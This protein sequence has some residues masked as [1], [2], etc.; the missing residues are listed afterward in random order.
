ME[1]ISSQSRGTFKNSWLDSKHSFSFGEYFNPKRMNF[2]TLRVIN[3]DQVAAN[4]GFPL[5]SHRDMEIISY[6]LEGALSHQDSLGNGSTIRP[7]DI[8]RM[9]AG[10][11]ILHSEF[12][13]SMSDKVHFLQIWLLPS[14]RGLAPDYAQQHFP[15]EQR[16]GQLRLVASPNGEQGSLPVNTD[17]YLYASILQAGDEIVYQKP[18]NRAVYVHVAKGLLVINDITLQAGD[19]AILDK[20]QEVHFSTSASAEF[21]LFDLPPVH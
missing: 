3:E 13:H 12:N 21:L 1:L 15:R 20:E 9:S 19:A 14:R 16:Y 10:T 8:Q 4:G 17:T 11:G 5:H 6:V 7:G 18:I 2:S